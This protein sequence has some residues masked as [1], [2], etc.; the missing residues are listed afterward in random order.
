M[1]EGIRLR[2]STLR[3]GMVRIAVP[4]PYPRPHACNYCLKL[5]LDH[6]HKFKT[7]HL[8]LDSA[9]YTF[10]STTVLERLQS[11]PDMAGF[12]VANTVKNPP[13]QTVAMAFGSDRVSLFRPL[14]PLLDGK[15][16]DNTPIAD[17][18]LED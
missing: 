17:Y 14:A 16:Q 15:A 6:V 5:G 10:V 4:R 13:T 3:S 18:R 1:S 2:H 8:L 12:T 7:Y 11:V 9:G